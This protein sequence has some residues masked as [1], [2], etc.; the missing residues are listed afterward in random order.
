MSRFLPN[1]IFF[2]AIS[3]ALMLTAFGCRPKT[4]EEEPI[5]RPPGLDGCFIKKDAVW[6]DRLPNS[7]EPDYTIDCNVVVTDEAYLQIEPG[8]II[9]FKGVGSGITVEKG[10]LKAAGLPVN[11]ITL[12]GK[13]SGVGT[14]AGIRFQTNSTANEVSNCKINNAG[15]AANDFFA[16]SVRGFANS[17]PS[18]LRVTDCEITQSGGFGVYCDAVSSFGAFQRNKFSG[19]AQAGVCITSAQL[20]ALDTDSN[21]FGNGLNFVQVQGEGKIKRNITMKRLNVPYLVNT[22]DVIIAEGTLVV[23]AGIE[24]RFKPGTSIQVTGGV[25]ALVAIGTATKPIV[26]KGVRAGIGAWRGIAIFNNS[27]ANV[28][29]YCDIDSGGESPMG[30]MV[31]NTKANVTVGN[32]AEGF[33][34]AAISNCKITNSGGWGIYKGGNEAINVHAGSTNS[35]IADVNTFSGNLLGGIG[36]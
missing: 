17:Y 27:T 7:T 29:T 25:G 26:F 4:V 22:G 19:C 20:G 10:A 33:P 21:Y 13:L 36:Q 15:S 3:C 34:Y 23:E 30:A 31:A 12:R 16:V 1:A 32:T 14:W 11:P 28:L 18:L 2:S 8:V 6:T 9:E 24:M 35:N 5:V